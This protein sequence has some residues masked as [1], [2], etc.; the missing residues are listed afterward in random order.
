VIR[1]LEAVPAPEKSCG[2]CTMCCKLFEVNWVDRPKPAGKWCHH[3]A[4]G[5]GCAIWQSR[6]EGCRDYFCVWRI[7]PEL[8]PEWRPDVAKFILTQMGP[9][10]PLTV[11][12][13]P[14]QPN[15][16]RREPYYSRLM[17]TTVE[18]L[19]TRRMALIVEGGRSRLVL[20]PDREVAIPASMPSAGVVASRIGAGAQARWDVRFAEATPPVAAPV[21]SPAA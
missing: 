18:L 3:C 20:L 11:V 7:D 6:P 19:E 2:A 17:R 9:A 21:T 16:W 14:A 15:A 8:A 5:R 13:D 12:V 1:E 10:F 4:P